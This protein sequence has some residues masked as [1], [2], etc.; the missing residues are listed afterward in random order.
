MPNFAC[1]RHLVSQWLASLWY[2]C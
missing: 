1:E 2:R